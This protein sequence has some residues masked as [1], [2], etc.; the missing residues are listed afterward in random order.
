MHERERSLPIWGSLTTA[1]ERALGKLLFGSKTM[2]DVGRSDLEVV[3][4]ACD[5][6][7]GTAFRFG[8]RRSGGCRYGEIA[9]RAPMVAKAVASS[10]AFPIL[11]PPLI[12]TFDFSKGG[13]GPG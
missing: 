7:T 4:N 5:L 6:R 11:L 12:E 13:R 9:G 1:F 3:V 8:S 10:A 2:A